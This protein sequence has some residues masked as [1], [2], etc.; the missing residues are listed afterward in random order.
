M[1][2]KPLRKSKSRTRTTAVSFFKKPKTSV[3]N[4]RA[5]AEMES[6]YLQDSYTGYRKAKFV[7]Q[8]TLNS[9]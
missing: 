4:G 5:M 2:M 7:K 1:E 3:Y 6:I 8:I 9:A